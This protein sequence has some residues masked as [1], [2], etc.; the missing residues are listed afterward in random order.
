MRRTISKR[1]C[2]F[3]LESLQRSLL[4]DAADRYESSP[5]HG[6]EV[7]HWLKKQLEFRKDNAE[8]SEFD[9]LDAENSPIALAWVLWLYGRSRNVTATDWPL[10]LQYG[11]RSVGRQQRFLLQRSAAIL[12]GMQ[13]WSG[14]SSLNPLLD[15][16]QQ[17]DVVEWFLATVQ[18]GRRKSLRY[19]ATPTPVVDTMIRLIDRQGDR[20]GEAWGWDGPTDQRIL[21]PAAGSGLFPRRLFH[22]W[23]SLQPEDS[24]PDPAKLGRQLW[25]RMDAIEIDPWVACAGSLL[26]AVDLHQSGTDLSCLP[27]WSIR[28]GDSLQAGFLNPGYGV[29]IGNP[30]YAALT[31]KTN[32]WCQ[33]LLGG[34]IDGIS[35][36]PS[37]RQKG[38]RKNWLHD[39]YIKFIRLGHYLV[40]NDGILCLVTNRSFLDG[41]GFMVLRRQLSQSFPSR[42]FIDLQFPARES[43]VPADEGRLFSIGSGVAIGLWSRRQP[44]NAEDSIDRFH[45]R[46]LRGSREDK[47]LQ[48]QQLQ[49]QSYA[50]TNENPRWIPNPID[51][52]TRREYEA[53]LSLDQVFRESWSSIV[54]A[55]DRV[56]VDTNRASLEERLAR[57]A[58]PDQ[59]DESIRESYFSHSRSNR[60]QAGDTRGW[61][62]KEAREKL[63]AMDWKSSLTRCLYR[64]MDPHWIFLHEDWIDWPRSRDVR[65]LQQP[66]NIGLVVRRAAPRGPYCYFAVSQ[67]PVIDGLLRSDNRGNETVFNLYGRSGESNVLWVALDSVCGELNLE[68]T[69]SVKPLVDVWKPGNE[70]LLKQLNAGRISSETVLSW[71]YAQ[72]WDFRYRTRF[73]PCLTQGFPRV[74]WPTTLAEARQ[75]LELGQRRIALELVGDDITSIP[76]APLLWA[77]EEFQVERRKVRYTPD[78]RCV[79][80]NSSNHFAA[81]AP[82]VWQHRQ[83]AYRV[84]EKYLKSRAGRV[85]DS[86][87]RS[88]LERLVTRISKL[89][90]LETPGD[91][92]L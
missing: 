27:A 45:Y 82:D 17:H 25:Q 15:H 26:L 75:R 43:Q 54:T 55:R 66:G 79:W 49:F 12:T 19:Y 1:A 88:A 73:A 34:Q 44:Q 28:V 29:V 74:S 46:C 2:R 42:Q 8:D 5:T 4:Q 51:T 48:L 62:L 35:Y 84:L 13:D 65:A 11:L 37:N 89:Q 92:T 10:I 30:P 16:L 40:A 61:R 32:T 63:K 3:F 22:Y 39:D 7:G 81:V 57:L 60:Y 85:L 47:E 67:L 90:S 14:D 21:D 24:P 18:P 69:D 58:D 71:V 64:P 56:V 6:A 70:I 36:L 91:T 31:Q 76:A 38:G 68:I 9:W 59:S 20:A 78:D 41:D 83:G 53:G 72:L 33:Q 80:I 23:L 87:E 86:W 77:N 52:Q 50:G